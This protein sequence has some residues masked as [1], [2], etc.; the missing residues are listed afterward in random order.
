MGAWGPRRARPVVAPRWEP[1]TG[2]IPT[3]EVGCADHNIL[4]QPLVAKL[5]RRQAWRPGRKVSGPPRGSRS[6]GWVVPGP[7]R[8][9][10]APPIK[11]GRQPFYS[12]GETGCGFLEVRPTSGDKHRAPRFRARFAILAR[13][14]AV[15][16]ATAIERTGH[17]KRCD[18]RRN[19]PSVLRVRAL[20]VRDCELRRTNIDMPGKRG[21]QHKRRHTYLQEWRLFRE[22]TLPQVAAL[23]GRDHSSLTRLET[24]KSAYT[25]RTL[26]QLAEV[27]HCDVTDLLSRDP[28]RPDIVAEAP[29]PRDAPVSP[30]PSMAHGGRSLSP[31]DL[32][33]RQ[34]EIRAVNRLVFEN[35]EG[36]VGD[37]VWHILDFIQRHHWEGNVRGDI[38]EIG[39]HH[40]KLFFLIAS[41]AHDDEVCVAMDLFEDQDLNI[42]GS[43]RGARAVFEQH[44]ANL[45]PHLKKRI[46]IVPIDS[47][48]MT[49]VTARRIVSERGARIFSSTADTRRR[50]LSMISASPRSCSFRLALYCS[51]TFSAPYGRP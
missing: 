15:A 4:G 48:S 2:E 32:K 7:S 27:Y 21:S 29:S 50:T 13:A 3:P 14:S 36:W 10:G 33:S 45:F 37:R 43:G 23:I 31:A 34:E 12:A 6:A 11:D 44:I 9:F 47:L 51:T 30:D 19:K 42:D 35:V 39:V 22:M 20:F 17:R 25:Q 1:G 16:D 40:G 5:L 41:L 8:G 18:R 28:S 46:R 38:A 26:E 49:P 24:G